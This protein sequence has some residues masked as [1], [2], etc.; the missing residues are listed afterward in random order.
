M[1]PYSRGIT[2]M[3]KP[4]LMI[5]I[6]MPSHRG[7]ESDDEDNLHREQDGNGGNGD[8]IATEAIVNIVHNLHRGGPLAIRRLR[9][10]AR[11]LEDLCQAVMKKDDYALEE[12]AA[13]ARDAL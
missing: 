5:A 4:S 2:V 6:G 11:G 1:T 9:L 7:E 8:D 12:A 3:P 13:D 10:L